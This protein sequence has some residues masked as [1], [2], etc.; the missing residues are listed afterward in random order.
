MPPQGRRG[1]IAGG[2]IALVL[3]AFGVFVLPFAFTTPPPIITRFVATRSFTP[4]NDQGRSIATVAIRLSEPSNVSIT[5][6]D[7]ASGAIVARLAD[8]NRTV[9]AL[10]GVAGTGVGLGANSLSFGDASNQSFGGTITG[11]G[12]IVKVGPP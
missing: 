4:G 11:S 10:S 3:V 2:V 5:I 12:G 8:G 6:K 7:P 1:L 9:G